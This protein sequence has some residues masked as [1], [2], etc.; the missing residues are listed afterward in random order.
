MKISSKLMS[1]FAGALLLVLP[2]AHA[3][4]AVAGP[5]AEKSGQGRR[6]GGPR[7]GGGME[8]MAKALE[9][10]P[11]QEAKWEAISAKERTAFEALRADTATSQDQ[12]RSKMREIGQ[13]HNAERRALLDATQ[14][15]KFDEMQARLRERGPGGPGGPGGKKKGQDN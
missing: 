7:G 10:T 6:E 13:A 2:V 1:V 14:Q 15:A 9:L 11:D 5:S 12:R 4:D 8:R 3:A